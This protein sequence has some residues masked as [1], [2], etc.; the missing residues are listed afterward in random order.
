MKVFVAMPFQENFWPVWEN[1]RDACKSLSLEPR[2]VDQL[3]QIKDIATTIFREIEQSDIIIVD[4]SGD[5]VPEIPNPN[6]VT[7][8]TYAR[9]LNKPIII[10]TQNIS[11]LPFDWRTHRA[12][13]YGNTSKEL[14]HFRQVF[15]ENLQGMLSQL[16]PQ[17]TIASNVKQEQ[18]TRG[19]KLLRQEWRKLAEQEWIIIKEQKRTEW[20]NQWINQRINEAEQQWRKAALSESRIAQVKEQKR[21]K[22]IN[23]RIEK[24]KQR[25]IKK[26]QKKGQKKWEKIEPLEREK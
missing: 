2:R 16:R 10:L 25:K 17:V 5:Q 21:M 4:F 18:E 7:E 23:Q 8:A 24:L 12:V 1:I 19:L 9:N 11:S 20:I 6:V 14:V 3:A 22:W 26:G 13:V 15:T